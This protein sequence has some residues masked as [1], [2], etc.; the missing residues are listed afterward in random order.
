MNN[1]IRLPVFGIRN[2]LVPIVAYNRGAG[3]HGRV[4]RTVRLSLAWGTAV[5]VVGA[6][7]FELFPAQMLV[8]FS[9]TPEMLAIGV[10]AF[11]IVGASILVSGVTVVLGGVFQAMD[12]SWKAMAVA[13]VQTVSLMGAATALGQLGNLN[14]VWCAFIASELIIA[15]LSVALY[16]PTRKRLLE[17]RPAAMAAD[18]EA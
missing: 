5:M 1:L 4:Q 12:E 2:A 11:R 7:L 17:G 18:L 15:A 10:P 14:L 16:V 8:A 3:L 9:A 13:I 6:A